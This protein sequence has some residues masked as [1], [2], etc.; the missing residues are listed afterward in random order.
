MTAFADSI[1]KIG[2]PKAA[3]ACGV[4]VRAVYKWLSQGALPRTDFTGETR[5]AEIL[6]TLSGGAFTADWLRSI[7]NPSA[8]GGRGCCAPPSHI[9]PKGSA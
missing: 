6:A 9:S 1:T 4:S 3:R 8:K 7:A 5:Y 2:V